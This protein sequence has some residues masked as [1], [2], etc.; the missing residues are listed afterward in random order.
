M[1]DALKRHDGNTL[2][3]PSCPSARASDSD[4]SEEEIDEALTRHDG[5]TSTDPTCPSALHPLSRWGVTTESVPCPAYHGASRMSNPYN[6]LTGDKYRRNNYNVTRHATEKHTTRRSGDDT[7]STGST[8]ATGTTGAVGTAGTAGASRASGTTEHLTTL[9]HRQTQKKSSG[10]YKRITGTT[11]VT[12]SAGTVKNTGTTGHTGATGKKANA[13]D[14]RNTG[15]TDTTRIPADI[16]EPPVASR[17]PKSHLNVGRTRHA[18]NTFSDPQCPI[19]PPPPPWPPDGHATTHSH[20][21]TTGLLIHTTAL[22][23]TTPT[24]HGGSCNWQT[25]TRAP[26]GKT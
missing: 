20:R 17:N 14:T 18:D 3:D 26:L 4:S 13:E 8:G 15:A 11:G 25:I 10:D 7:R 1:D 5:T 9:S 19:A 23:P 24:P 12:G 2:K 21:W 22:R 16:T 6:D